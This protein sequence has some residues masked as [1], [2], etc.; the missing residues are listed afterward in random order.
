MKI[1]LA[2]LEEDVN[3]LERITAVIN[4]KYYEKLEI[5]SY[6]KLENAIDGL[7]TKKIDVFIANEKFEIDTETL[8][9]RCCFAYF[10]E[11]TGVESYKDEIAI[12]KFQKIELIYKQILNIYS[13]RAT[14]FSGKKNSNSNVK[15]IYVTSF[16]GGVG[17]SSVAAACAIK[18]ASENKKVLYLNLEKMG[19]SS[20]YFSGEGQFTF[21]DIIY[22][23]KSKKSNLMLKIESSVRKSSEGVDYF[24]APQ[25]SLDMLELKH[26]EVECLVD[27]ILSTSKYEY[28]VVDADGVFDDFSKMLWSKADVV[29]IVSDGSEVSNSKFER[30]YTSLELINERSEKD[31]RLEK[32]AMI[33]NKF[34]NKTS[35]T[36]EELEIPELG[37]IPKFEHA[38]TSE[39]IHTIAGMSVFNKLM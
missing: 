11:S 21:S 6:T 20:K 32:A 17:K 39:V 14:M 35:R 26:E 7:E 4:T 25:V 36:I 13:E 3:Y 19:D 27:E 33:Y 9:Q 23:L 1:K 28:V 24:A 22:A 31:Y 37:G 12:S 29:V 15:M 30:T 5:Y 16:S 8:P 34:S 10:V 18:F 2:I 38:T